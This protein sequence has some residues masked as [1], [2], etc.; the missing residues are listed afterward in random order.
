MPEKIALT[1]PP[2][3]RKLRGYA[4]DPSMSL[5]LDT[6]AVNKVVYRVPWEADLEKG[7]KGEYVEVV[8]ED[9]NGK[10]LYG[11]VDLNFNY[12]LAQD[13][14]DPD[15]NDPFF[16]QQMVYAV[17]MTTIKNFEKALGRKVL[18]CHHFKKLSKPVNNK[19]DDG[20]VQ[21]LRLL[22]HAFNEPNAYF[23]PE[24]NALYLGYF[25]AGPEM[26]SNIHPSQIYSCL[27]HDVVAHEA[28]HAIIHGLY[29]SYTDRTNPDVGAFHEAFADITALFQHFTFP[30]VL[31][32]QIIKHNGDL[33]SNNIMV[34]I[35][36][37]FGAGIGTEGYLRDAVGIIDP[38]TRVWR[39]KTPSDYKYKEIEEEHDRGAI[40]LSVVFEAFNTIYKRNIADLLR[41]GSGGVLGSAQL[42]PDLASRLSLEATK[43]AALVH[44]M[45]IRAL[46]YCPPTDITFGD[47]LRA[48]VTSDRDINGEDKQSI[49]LAFIDAFRRW[50]VY[51]EDVDS[52][53]EES[54]V[55]SA[56]LAVDSLNNFFKLTKILPF[57]REF[58]KEIIHAET[59]RDIFNITRTYIAGKKSEGKKGLYE[60]IVEDP[61][62]RNS[63]DFLEA[64]GLY[65]GKNWEKFGIATM[66]VNGKK[67]PSFE[68]HSLHLAS[69]VTRSG[70]SS[71]QIILTILQRGRLRKK[72]DE[73]I[74]TPVPNAKNDGSF[75]QFTGGVTLIF[76][77][78]SLA[79]RYAIRK[80]L[81][82][83]SNKRTG[84]VKLD[85]IRA[86]E[87]FEYVNKLYNQ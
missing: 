57:L 1:I 14:L 65:L 61:E 17:T 10:K 37:E 8:D 7:P 13:G 66:M 18:W 2:V 72:K 15:K 77:L 12:I 79:L 68:I 33:A 85:F 46:D 80:P 29:E 69:R 58:R 44:K 42:Q 3:H 67:A 82:Q 6:A 21:R 53:S 59:R 84:E 25:R 23:L 32:S 51:P 9:E 40:L 56:T 28:A 75:F 5:Q 86:M 34:K 24:K 4:I 87:K 76:D 64:S 16:H 60:L 73:K 48:I 26:N 27:S 31:K 45:C 35:A 47:F 70:K 39:M 78:D 49:R 41:M 54:L 43:A 83:I 38:K 62:L 81:V 71:N 30:E 63:S 36:A 74:F 22:P 52:L 19:G 11:P 50:G 55:Y 20:Y